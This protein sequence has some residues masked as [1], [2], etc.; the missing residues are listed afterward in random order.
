M[1]N[2]YHLADGSPRYGSRNAETTDGPAAPAPVVRAEEI[3]EA[4][5]RLGLD[6][7]AAAIDRRLTRPWADTPDPVV[8]GLRRKYPEE[9][10]A[11][12]ALV[13]IH[14]GS[15]RQWRLKAQA[16]RDKQMAP[17]VA[18]RK[19]AGS[20]REILT[21]RLGLLASLIAPPVFVVATDQDNIVKLIATGA[22]CFAAALAGGQALT[23]R[24]RIP[25]MPAIR[26][27]WLNELRNDVVNATLATILENKGIV[28]APETAAA[29]RCGWLSIQAAARSAQALHA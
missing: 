13:R 28:L 26:G 5:A 18:R 9:L 12:R 20:A 29:A 11:S 24:A 16:V 2:A 8:A 3:A 25:V 21:L 1:T 22:V 17:T 4:T 7:L 10:A 23:L 15:Q 14:L 19:A 27:L 6:E